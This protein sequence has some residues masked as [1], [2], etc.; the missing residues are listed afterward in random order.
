[1]PKGF[2]ASTVNGMNGTA[3]ER[4]RRSQEARGGTSFSRPTGRSL[5]EA[6]VTAEVNKKP[7][8]V[9]SVDV[10]QNGS[11]TSNTRRSTP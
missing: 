10:Q 7:T 8:Y 3:F 11:S 4:Q 2:S 9:A 6:Q 1:M 5:G